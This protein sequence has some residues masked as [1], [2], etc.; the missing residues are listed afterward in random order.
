[1]SVGEGMKLYDLDSYSISYA[2]KI[3]TIAIN[4]AVESVGVK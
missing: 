2:D 1:M 4:G 3:Y